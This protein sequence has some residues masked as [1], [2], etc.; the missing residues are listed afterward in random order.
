MPPCSPTPCAPPRIWS[1]PSSA[2]YN[3]AAAEGKLKALNERT[4][5]RPNI[6]ILIADD[7]GWGEPGAYAGGE[8]I[9]AATPNIDRLAREGLKLTSAYSQPTCTPT[10]SALV[11]GRLPVRTGLF[12]PILAGDKLTANPW[13]SETSI[14]TILSAAGYYTALIGK[15]HVG[16]AVGMRPQDI[17]FDEFYGYYRRPGSPRT[18]WSSSPPTT[19]RRWTPGRTRA[20]RRS[21]APS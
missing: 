7:L 10:R 4:G 20:P 16:E 15:W 5:K 13:E 11:T 21:A 1:P 9:G 8:A 6:L 19:A 12:R 17:G 14:G 3:K 18:P 2:L